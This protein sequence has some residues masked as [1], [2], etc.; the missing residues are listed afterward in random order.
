M[1]RSYT[2]RQEIHI[3]RTTTDDVIIRTQVHIKHLAIS[4]AGSYA[5]DCF[6]PELMCDTGEKALIEELRTYLRPNEAPPW[7]LTRLKDMLD[8]YCNDE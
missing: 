3:T 8:S 6:Q 1:S 7:L 5:Q 4:G 2:R